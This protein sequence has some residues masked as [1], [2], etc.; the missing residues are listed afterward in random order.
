[1]PFPNDREV[2]DFVSL[3]D[4]GEAGKPEAEAFVARFS[5]LPFDE[6]NPKAIEIPLTEVHV[7]KSGRHPQNRVTNP[8]N[9]KTLKHAMKNKGKKGG[10][11]GM[12]VGTCKLFF[13]SHAFFVQKY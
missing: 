12:K 4:A 13:V 11:E 3:L 7:K 6:K 10:Y 2:D 9:L 5:K 1:M 8:D